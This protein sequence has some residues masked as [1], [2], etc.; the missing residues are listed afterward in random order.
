MCVGCR[1]S[2]ETSPP[3]AIR[4]G[5]HTYSHPR[6]PFKSREFIEREFVE[7]QRAIQE[8]TGITPMLLRAPYGHRWLGMRQVQEQLSLLSVMW[9]RDWLRLALDSRGHHR[10]RVAQVHTGRHYLPA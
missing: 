1:T 5:N 4:S 8:E 2:P 6:L 7:A 9:D 3:A 10:L